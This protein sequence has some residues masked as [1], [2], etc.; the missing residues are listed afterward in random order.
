LKIITKKGVHLFLMVF[1]FMGFTVNLPAREPTLDYSLDQ[2]LRLAHQSNLRLKIAGLEQDIAVEEYRDSRA[3]P[4]PELEYSRGKGQIPGVPEDP[5]LWGIGA[6]WSMPNP[7]YRYFFLKSLRTHIAEADITAEM[8]RRSVTK[9]LKTHYYRLQFNKKIEG[10]LKEKLRILEEVNTITRAKVSIG[11]AK[12]LDSLRSSVEIQKNKTALFRTQKTIAFE[13]TKLNEF[14]NYTLP[15]NF[16]VTE[17]FSF[18]PLPGV[19]EDIQRAIETSPFIRLNFTRW[20]RGQANLQAAH[21]SILEEI[22]VFGEQEKEFEGKKWKVGIGISIPIFNWKSAHLR[23]AKLEKQKARLE[24]EHAKKHFFA[25]VQ[26]LVA[27]IRVVENE[28]QT[29]QGALLKE[30]RE[31]M[32]TS[33]RLYKAGEIPLVVFLDSQNSFF[34]VQERCYEAI[35]EWNLLKAD[36]EELLGEEQ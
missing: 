24:Y 19:E 27:E 34:E 25:D 35:T 2:L 9:G 22:E 5:T 33:E 15:E 23:K 31:N 11:E 8:T 16:G 10:F 21:A 13:H 36:L 30:G 18:H 17:D 6:K 32:D 4:N 7:F 26:Q 20:K 12:E 3:L 14:L 28:I 1:L 29:F